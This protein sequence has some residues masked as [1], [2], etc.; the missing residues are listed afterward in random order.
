M[1]NTYLHIVPECFVDTNLVQILMQIKGVNHQNSCGQVTNVL[2][3]KFKDK[4]AI[5]IVDNDNLQ[6]N[7]SNACVEI[8]HSEEITLCKHPDNQHYLIKINHIMERFILNSAEDAN[9]DLKEFNIPDNLEGL[10]NITKS[11]DCLDN[12]DLRRA[13]KA[14]NGANEMRLLAEVLNYLQSK[15]YSSDGNEL[16]EIFKAHG[17]MQERK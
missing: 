6:S 1:K 12:H 14:V 9:V 3:N 17:F 10:K 8:A 7:Y 11:K 5:G 2:K 13:I 16:I 4:F 15:K